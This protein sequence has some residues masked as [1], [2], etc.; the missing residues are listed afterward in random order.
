MKRYWKY[1]KPYLPAFIIGPILMIV[2]VIGEVVLPKF[3]ANIINIGAANHDVPYIIGMG[4][5]MV[6]TA[7]LMMAGGVGGAYFAAKAAISFSSDLRSDVFDQVQK[8]S[9]ANLD[10]FSTGSLVTRLT[11]DITQVQNLINMALRM[12]LRAPG[13]L[14][15]ALIMAFMMNARLALVI[16][17]VIPILIL[18]IVLIIKTAF[19]RF[20]TMQKKLDMLNSNIQEV[21]TNVR[22]V[23]SFVRGEYE[24]ERFAKSNEN[25][26]TASLSAF[27]A[28]IFTMPVMMFLM[29]ATTLAVVWFGG[30]Q[31]LA[32][33]MPVGDLTAFTSYIVQILMSLM[34]LAMVLL[35]SSR[36]IASL[37]RIMEVLDTKVTLTDE[38][39]ALPDKTVDSGRVEF[40]DVTFRYY[41]EN[42]EPVLSHISFTIETGQVLGIIGSTG[43]GKTT[44]VQMIPRLYD[45]D[46]GEVLVDGVNVKDYSLKH[47]R[48]GVGMVLQKN[49]LFSGSIM[50]NLMWGDEQ[51]LEEE[52]VSAAKA[53]QAD[54]FVNSFT[55]GYETELGQGGVNVSGG[56]KQR[57]CIA[58]ALL[59]KPK[60]LILDDSTSAVDTA[61]EAKIRES[62]SG[63]LKDTTKIIIAQRI[64]S[65][66]EADKILVLDDGE[67]VGMGGHEQLLADCEAYR[68]IY[69]SQMD[70]EV[71]AS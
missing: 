41:K 48:E 29:N 3:M 6:I 60:I 18:V 63:T 40:K 36:A 7:L 15:G 51:A 38:G 5:V 71:S 10:R 19:P 30:K 56:Q 11:N 42:K 66:M 65:V 62:F 58:R 25:L 47:L 70:K 2:E 21:L 20:D 9:F 34:M 68:E 67:I 46:Q 31:I 32:G 35:Q 22:V 26:K 1:I 12:M 50:E 59:K 27:N 69:Y 61:T 55:E 49:V 52:I 8:F 45:V 44:L 4:V 53:A 13:M 17:V 14:I 43:S 64:T 39:C 57:L 23:K 33:Q 24:E 28:I 16:L 37:H 54:D